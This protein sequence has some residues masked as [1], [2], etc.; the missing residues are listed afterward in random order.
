V[1]LPLRALAALVAVLALAGCGGGGDGGTAAST[2]GATLWVTQDAGAK[3]V[4]TAK[5]PVGDSVLQALD[6]H[7]DVETSYG[8]RFVQA[9][10]GIAGS[11]GEQHD[12]FFFVNGIEP[13]VGSDAVELREGDVAWWDYRDWSQRMAAP[14]VVGAFPEPFR[15][16]WD[17]KRRPARIVAPAGFEAEA[18]AL[19]R[20]L[21]GPGGEG[22]PN[23]FRLVVDRGAE[24]A[25]LRAGRGPSDDSPATFRLSGAETAVRAAAR[26]LAADPA[27]VRF[28]YTARF[29][30]SGKVIG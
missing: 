28:R 4:L 11:L 8:G 2:G 20:V 21:G 16:G 19:L 26:A 9:V 10:N 14:I 27:I 25:T 7:A 3:V 18:E 17:G 12:W 13:G 1:R 23:V 22:E 29:D 30:A 24:G 6:R 15:H 5:V